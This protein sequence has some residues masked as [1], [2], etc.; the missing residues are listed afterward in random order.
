MI[1]QLDQKANKQSVSNALHR[2]ANKA[3]FEQML[4]TKVDMV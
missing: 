4:A 3:E 2:K 1:E